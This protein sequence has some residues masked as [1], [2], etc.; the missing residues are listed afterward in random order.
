MRR[1][2]F[3]ALSIGAVAAAD[4]QGAY[5]PARILRQVAPAFPTAAASRGLLAGRAA[6]AVVVGTDGLVAE[7]LVAGY[8][9]PEFGEA[10][11]EAVRQWTF[12]PASLDGVL[13]AALIELEV[14]FG[15]EP[16]Q[17]HPG[18]EPWMFRVA[19]VKDVDRVPAPEYSAPPANPAAPGTPGSARDVTVDFYIDEQGHVRLPTAAVGSGGIFGDSAVA[20]LRRW[21][22]AIPTV[23]GRPA[24]LKTS[25]VLHFAAAGAPGMSGAPTVES[26]TPFA[27]TSEYELPGPRYGAAAVADKDAVYIIGGMQGGNLGIPLGDILRF[28]IHTH[29]ITVLTRDL[30]WRVHPGAVLVNGKIYVMG[31][32]GKIGNYWSDVQVFDLAT[33]R[34]SEGPALPSPRAFFAAAAIGN[35]IYVA[36]GT[37]AW[38][39]RTDEVDCLD[40]ARGT[41]SRCAAMPV[42]TAVHGAVAGDHLILPGGFDPEM[43]RGNDSLADVQSFD[44]STGTWCVLQPL[45]MTMDTSAVAAVAGRLFVFGN[46]RSPAM[47]VVY[48]ISSG[49]SQAYDLGEV[50]GR[51][52]AVAVVDRTIYLIGGNN[53]SRR[54]HLAENR[55]EV[56]EV[57]PD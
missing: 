20:A 7:S 21:K 6:M 32:L 22:F 8:T 26:K 40:L 45:C 42:A 34:I 13:R 52:A 39:S 12:E 19:T 33:G 53:P 25:L 31:G 41:W 48:D 57:G 9:Q 37:V 4:P 15:R 30:I 36:G 43:S 54:L 5:R 10:A 2:L 14:P 47:L 49:K 27:G 24:V 56:F 1:L 28:D 44:P 17:G 46:N 35:R 50:T 51:N 55:I 18:R 38:R 16:P 23:H 3:I 11:A 29:R